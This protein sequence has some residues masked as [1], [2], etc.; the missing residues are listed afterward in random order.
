M[1]PPADLPER[2]PWL[3]LLFLTLAVAAGVI[4]LSIAGGASVGA[5]ESRDLLMQAKQVFGAPLP[6]V[7]SSETNL[8]TPAKVRLGKIL[9]YET[10][11]SNDGTVSCARCHPFSLYA[12]DGLKK[13]IGNQCKVNSR[14]A[15]TLL[16]AA[17]QISAHWTGNRRDVE[18]QATQSLLGPASFAMASAESVLTAIVGYLPL[19]KEAFPGDK[20][21]IRVENFGKAIGAFERTL[22]TPSP[23]DDFLKGN[24]KALR[25]G[26]RQG[27]KTFIDMGC[28]NCHS[29]TYVGGQMYQKFG[30]LEPYWTYT[31]SDT[32]DQG[33]YEVTKQESDKY[34]FKVPI[35][36]NVE[37]TLPYFHDGSVSSLEDAVW[38]MGKI[39]LGRD[40]TKQEKDAIQSFLASLTGVIPEDALKLP[41]LPSN[42]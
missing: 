2:R 28:V 42:D 3:A 11:V 18:D 1:A 22:V 14:N 16:N 6:Q 4:M 20:N 10:R 15:P 32:I 34:L 21:P 7:I 19:F 13:S 23:F 8:I 29:G 38:I 24:E 9:F 26:Q 39:Q 27:L 37:K 5:D 36:R 31:K 40:L 30:V 41:I 35:L 12:T 33:R 25:E 17:G